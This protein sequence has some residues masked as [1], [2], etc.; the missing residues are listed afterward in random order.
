MFDMLAFT[1]IYVGWDMARAVERGGGPVAYEFCNNFF[2]S[3]KY[4]SF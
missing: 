4:T 3:Q 2:L 1:L